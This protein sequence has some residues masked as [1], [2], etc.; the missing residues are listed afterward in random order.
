MPF[1]TLAKKIAADKD[2]KDCKKIYKFISGQTDEISE[3]VA[4][5][6]AKLSE[7]KTKET[8]FSARSKISDIKKEFIKSFSDIDFS[9]AVE[10]LKNLRDEIKCKDTNNSGEKADECKFEEKLGD[11]LS[12][13]QSEI[14]S[15]IEDF[16]SEIDDESISEEIDS[17]ISELM[18]ELDSDSSD[19]E[20]DE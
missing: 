13:L 10:E 2:A 19:E 8:L 7:A 18:S 4:E 3:Y 20:D 15:G 1:R 6:N 14:E 11:A 5:L 9:D 17:A 16:V 12:E